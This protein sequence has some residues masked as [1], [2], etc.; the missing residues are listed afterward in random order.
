[1]VYGVFDGEYS[2][3][4]VRGYFSTREEA[5]KYCCIHTDCYIRKMKDLSSEEDLS[6]VVVYYE[7]EIGFECECGGEQVHMING[8]PSP[9]TD[10]T[11]FT[12]TKNMRNEPD[13]HDYYTANDLR[14]DYIEYNFNNGWI[15]FHINTPKANDRKRCEKIAQDYLAELYG[16]KGYITEEDINAMNEKFREVMY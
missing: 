1:M 13:R 8:K 15:Y 10:F 3:W 9:W 7:Q 4:G 11:T 12:K 16:D 6:D 5:E 2:D 14:P